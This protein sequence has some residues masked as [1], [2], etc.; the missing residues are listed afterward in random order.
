MVEKLLTPT[1]GN[2]EFKN[3]GFFCQFEY[4]NVCSQAIPL[5][6]TGKIIISVYNFS[7][8]KTIFHKIY[9]ILNKIYQASQV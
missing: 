1:P 5:M 2:C 9:L 4:F 8:I 6:E 7:I 3:Y